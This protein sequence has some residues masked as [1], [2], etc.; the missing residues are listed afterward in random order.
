MLW[1][2]Q[3]FL[4]HSQLGEQTKLHNFYSNF[5][6]CIWFSYCC[7]N[8]SFV[9][10]LWEV[11]RLIH[12]CH[13]VPLPFS[14][15]AM[16]FVKVC[17]VAGNIWTASPTVLRIGMLLIT[18]FVELCVVAGRSRMRAGSPHAVSGRSMVIHTCH[19]VLCRGL[20]KSL[21]ERHGHGMAWGRHGMCES[22]TAALC[23][24]NGK[25]TI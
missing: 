3:M 21:S 11:V 14:D 12:T 15:S 5:T 13:A 7:P 19:A 20:E 16:S 25:D 8:S 22:N 10:R 6:C 2:R 18:T 9:V 17:V 4:Y 1:I 24:S 23:K